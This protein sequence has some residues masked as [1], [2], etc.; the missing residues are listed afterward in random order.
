M[1]DVY[2]SDPFERVAAYAIRQGVLLTRNGGQLHTRPLGASENKLLSRKLDE[3][4][5]Q[6][7]AQVG[8]VV[9]AY[10]VEEAPLLQ[11]LPKELHDAVKRC[12][13]LSLSHLECHLRDLSFCD[14]RTEIL[15]MWLVELSSSFPSSTEHHPADS[16]STG[17]TG[18][19]AV[20]T[21]QQAELEEQD[22]HDWMETSVIPFIK[23]LSDADLAAINAGVIPTSLMK[24]LG[25]VAYNEIERRREA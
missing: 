9:E 13:S 17:R 19:V 5:R 10:A 3:Q 11:S 12:I 25:R 18:S 24:M 15:H 6:F 2:L 4:K 8:S 21:E 16:H 20:S 1:R 22:S 7:L 23:R 14:V